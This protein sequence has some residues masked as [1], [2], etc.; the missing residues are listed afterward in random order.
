MAE[1][2]GR[3]K[4]GDSGKVVDVGEK[5]PEIV[6]TSKRATKIVVIQAGGQE[7][8]GEDKVE[9]GKELPDDR[10]NSVDS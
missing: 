2:L 1:V 3:V 7:R 8:E 5:F 9:N 4:V 6:S 10:G